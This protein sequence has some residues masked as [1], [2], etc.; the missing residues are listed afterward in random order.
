[1][2]EQLIIIIIIVINI[3]IYFFLFLLPS[4]FHSGIGYS[5]NLQLF[6]SFLTFILSKIKIMK[7][8]KYEIHF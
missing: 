4:Y 1:M 7:I 3:I 6:F 8:N 2:G 5:Y